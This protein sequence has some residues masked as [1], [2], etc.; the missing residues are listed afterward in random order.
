MRF[1]LRTLLI[2]LIAPL[3]LV[4]TGYWLWQR[5]IRV[6]SSRMQMVIDEGYIDEDGVPRRKR[7][8]INDPF[9]SAGNRT[10]R[11]RPIPVRLTTADIP[12]SKQMQLQAGD[13]YVYQLPNGKSVAIWCGRPGLLGGM[14]DDSKSG[15]DIAWGERPFKQP[16]LVRKGT[17]P[18]PDQMVWKSYIEQGP[19]V[20]SG[21]SSRERE[22]FVG[23]LQLSIIEDLTATGSLPVTVSV[24][25]K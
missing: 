17:G 4:G 12:Y 15:L 16:P 22:L 9:N 8:I 2:L 1:R 21:S 5:S 18:D 23:D 25:K 19:V 10:V 13:A 24:A 14:F 3:V 20:T 6:A 7:R 11:N